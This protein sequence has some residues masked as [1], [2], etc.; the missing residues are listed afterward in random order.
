MPPHHVGR[1]EVEQGGPPAH[2]RT[3]QEHEGKEV[4]EAERAD[5]HLAGPETGRLRE[6][7]KLVRPEE[8]ENEK[9][10]DCGGCSPDR[11]YGERVAGGFV[12]AGDAPPGGGRRSRE[13]HELPA[14][15]VEVPVVYPLR[16]DAVTRVAEPELRRYPER[17]VGEPEAQHLPLARRPRKQREHERTRQKENHVQR[18]HVEIL[19][20]ICEQEAERA[21]RCGVAVD[22]F[23]QVAHSRQEQPRCQAK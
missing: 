13:V 23:K 9:H 16:E 20:C 14:E 8:A 10:D 15:R 4:R 1:P 19:G 17:E 2:N 18:Q 21:S 12:P 5:V 3:Y 7:D 22:G 6:G 11:V